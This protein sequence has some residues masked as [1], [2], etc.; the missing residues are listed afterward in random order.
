MKAA[1]RYVF[2]VAVSLDQVANAVLGGYPDETVSIRAAFA[3]NR[4]QRWGC[5]LCKLL[6]F[7]HPNHCS[8]AIVLRRGAMMRAAKQQFQHG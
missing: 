1:L 8:R 3:R 6:D 7:F 2:F 4:G 5:V